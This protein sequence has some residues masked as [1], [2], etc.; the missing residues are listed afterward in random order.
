MTK[1]LRLLIRHGL[2]QGWRRGLLGGNRVW[3]VVG[4]VAIIG[5]LGARALA[6]EPDVIFSELL[7]PGQT[8]TVRHVPRP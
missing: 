5:H 7:E 8:F 2:R 6:G 4:G 1:L 3:V